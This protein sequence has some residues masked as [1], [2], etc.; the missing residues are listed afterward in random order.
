MKT[1]Y[2]LRQATAAELV[3]AFGSAAKALDATGGNNAKAC[4]YL[5]NPD[6]IPKAQRVKRETCRLTDRLL[7]FCRLERIKIADEKR[8]AKEQAAQQAAKALHDRIANAWNNEGLRA[9]STIARVVGVSRARV[10]RV[11]SSLKHAGRIRDTSPV[12]ETAP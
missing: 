6:Q 9:T 2:P 5:A 12:K 1:N 7:E 3:A 11:V 4:F 8:A 10:A